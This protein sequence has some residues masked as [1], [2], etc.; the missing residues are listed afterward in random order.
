MKSVDERIKEVA[1]IL[2]QLREHG[3]D[4]DPGALQLRDDMNEFV[5]HGEEKTGTS[6][7]ANGQEIYWHMSNSFIS[8]V[9]VMKPKPK[10]D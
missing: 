9:H 3:M 4:E 7:L 10:Q 1:N 8:H 5:R 2:Y 6:T